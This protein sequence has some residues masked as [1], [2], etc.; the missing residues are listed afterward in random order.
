MKTKHWVLLQVVTLAVGFALGGLYWGDSEDHLLPEKVN[1]TASDDSTEPEVDSEIHPKPV[2]PDQPEAAKPD[3]QTQP[4][5]T[6]PAP[7]TGDGEVTVI[8]KLPDGSPAVGARL[9]IS[10][11]STDSDVF[12]NRPR[13]DGFERFYEFY[14]AMGQQYLAIY[15]AM[16]ASQKDGITDKNGRVLFTGLDA[17]EVSVQLLN[18]AFQ[19][20]N[21]HRQNS[22][23]GKVEIEDTLEVMVYKAFPFKLTAPILK[24]KEGK[25]VGSWLRGT[26]KLTADGKHEAMLVEGDYTVR[27]QDSDGLNLSRDI[28]FS[29]PDIDA[30]SIT[31]D[32]G[33]SG[34]DITGKVIPRLTV[35]VVES[36]YKLKKFAVIVAKPLAGVE[37]ERI[38]LEN[39]SAFRA[40]R[41]SK[42]GIYKFNPEFSGAAIVGIVDDGQVIVFQEITLSTENTKLEFLL[43][44]NP[45]RH[46]IDVTLNW[47]NTPASGETY[48]RLA[49]LTS[50]Q[51]ISPMYWKA[52]ATEH[53]VSYDLPEG[54]ENVKLTFKSSSLG[55][56]EVELP[57]IPRQQVEMELLEPCNPTLKISGGPT[58][59]NSH[60]WRISRN[61]EGGARESSGW[62]SGMEIASGKKEL[63][64]VQPGK[65]FIVFTLNSMIYFAKEYDFE[66]GNQVIEVTL[67]EFHTLIIDLNGRKTW[68]E[69]TPTYLDTGSY[70]PHSRAIDGIIVYLQMPAGRYKL[71]YTDV[72]SGKHIEKEQEFIL[73]SDMT[74]VLNP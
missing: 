48:F 5:A 58:H 35:I 15:E 59:K 24:G 62:I 49:N 63:Y 6:S 65:Y 57:A 34:L 9:C 31:D 69:P 41:I 1:S 22:H 36:K 45:N 67:P 64:S 47:Q 50:R 38:L 4:Q 28:K 70:I 17:N 25:M 2:A 54:Y 16:R 68:R 73:S 71:T 52:S 74:V 30:L 46:W 72:T 60:H 21:K 56:K 10:Q 27:I 32:D 13:S 37:P 42:D 12:R 55:V 40:A 20:S 23:L 51:A 7:L 29:I 26:A 66:S 11:F 53:R 39:R 44:P 14:K 3:D 43:E 61:R 19:A 8:L 18:C 33:I